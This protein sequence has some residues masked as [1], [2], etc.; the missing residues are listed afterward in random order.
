MKKLW[1]VLC[2]VA[3]LDLLFLGYVL[4]PKVERPSF[5]KILPVIDIPLEELDKHIAEREASLPVKE[6]NESRIIWADSAKTKTPLS[7]VYL[8]G[9]SA[10]AVEGDPVHRQ[11][12]QDLG[13]NLYLPRLAEHGLS[14]DEALLDITADA[15]VDSAKEALSIAQ[16]IG[17]RV[18]IVATSNGG[19]LALYLA[20]SIPELAALILYSPNIEIYDPTAKLLDDPW[21]LEIAKKVKGSNYHIANMPDSRKP[22]WY[23][24]YRLESLP[25]LQA[26]ISR[27]MT[28]INFKTVDEPVFLGYYYKN[29][30]EQDKV[31]SVPAMLQMY[32][33]LG[34]PPSKKKKQAFPEAGD[35]ILASPLASNDVKGVYQATRNFLEEIVGLP[36]GER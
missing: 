31:V 6:G 32:E 2:L 14:S 26:F 3:V 19:A 22:Y 24:K 4:G 27:A 9:W 18:V 33:Q 13:A 21:G 35:H 15:L 25:Q 12:A 20:E 17:D 7:V 23:H 1:L 28:P 11:I 10:S 8:H 36:I 30:A 29:E 16:L 5:D 34:T